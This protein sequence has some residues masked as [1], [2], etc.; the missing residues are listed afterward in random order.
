MRPSDIRQEFCQNIRSRIHFSKNTLPQKCSEDD[1]YGIR[2]I[3]EVCPKVGEQWKSYVKQSCSNWEHILTD[4]KHTE[5]PKWGAYFF[6]IMLVVVGVYWKYGNNSSCSQK[7][8]R[9]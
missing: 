4:K 3:D 5:T 6:V 8:Y 9:R 2:M 7:A 1:K